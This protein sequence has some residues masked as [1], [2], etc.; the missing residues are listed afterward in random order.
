MKSVGH[1]LALLSNQWI[2]HTITVTVTKGLYLSMLEA[3]MSLIAVNLPSL[4]FLCSKR[5][6]ELSLR[7]I[8]SVLS[9]R[10]WTSSVGSRHRDNTSRMVPQRVATDRFLSS[11]CSNIIHDADGEAYES[12]SMHGKGDFDVENGAGKKA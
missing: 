8:R 9:L 5:T 2:T 1:L 12:F 4:W 3:G 10:S 11:S 7:S 6:L